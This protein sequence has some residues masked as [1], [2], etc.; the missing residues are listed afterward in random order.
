MPAAFCTQISP[1]HRPHLIPS[2]WT[3]W[4]FPGAGQEQ[5]WLNL[6]ICMATGVGPSLLNTAGFLGTEAQL[7]L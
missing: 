4:S 7:A 2:V 6:S 5:L 3:A 1:S